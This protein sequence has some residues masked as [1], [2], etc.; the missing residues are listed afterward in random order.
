[1]HLMRHYDF[2]IS[3]RAAAR[4]IRYIARVISGALQLNIFLWKGKPQYGRLR[5]LINE[6]PFFQKKQII[7]NTQIFL[8]GHT[9]LTWQVYYPFDY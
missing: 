7:G 8:N 4:C 6:S 9:F 3:Y 5:D 1:M 2:K